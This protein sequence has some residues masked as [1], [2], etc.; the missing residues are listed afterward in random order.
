V[1]NY[2]LGQH[3]A[4]GDPD[5]LLD[6]ADTFLFD[7]LDRKN[8]LY[9]RKRDLFA[10]GKYFV[11]RMIAAPASVNHEFH[12]KALTR[13]VE[14]LQL[15]FV[16]VPICHPEMVKFLY[17][18][19]KLIPEQ[20]VEL[21]LNQQLNHYPNQTAWYRST[22]PNWFNTFFI[23][24]D[25]ELLK[26]IIIKEITDNCSKYLADNRQDTVNEGA[27]GLLIWLNLLHDPKYHD[28]K[29]SAVEKIVS[30]IYMDRTPANPGLFAGCSGIGLTLLSCID[31][32]C[33]EWKNLL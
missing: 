18:A 1:M 16:N 14:I 20:S 5:D 22:I 7:Y 4:A 24:E 26:E 15:H 21:L 23:P 32:R 29:K 28:L 12:L 17:Q 10:I 31:N 13:T 6:E 8:V 3:F 27:S 11:L 30:D 9:L 2:L 25:H 19:S 33:N